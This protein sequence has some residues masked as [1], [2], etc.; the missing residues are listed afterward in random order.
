[1]SG[2]ALVDRTDRLSE[3][4]AHARIVNGGI[5]LLALSVHHGRNGSIALRF[6]RRIC[7]LGAALIHLLGDGLF[8]LIGRIPRSLRARLAAHGFLVSGVR[9]RHDDCAGERE[10]FKHFGRNF[11][12]S[13]PL[14]IVKS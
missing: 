1:M 3:A 2:Y 7:N 10:A 13:I 8:G 12:M 11:H 5:D 9:G 14:K 6:A 4:R